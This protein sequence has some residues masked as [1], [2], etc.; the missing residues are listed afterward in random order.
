M[1]MHSLKISPIALFHV[2]RFI[3]ILFYFICISDASVDLA[4]FDSARLDS[5]FV[6]AFCTHERARSH[7]DAILLKIDFSFDEDVATKK[8]NKFNVILWLKI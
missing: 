8:A 1:R 4:R 2:L 6:L 3:F 7:S 5:T